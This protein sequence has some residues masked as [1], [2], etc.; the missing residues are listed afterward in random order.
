MELRCI[1]DKED[2][3]RPSWMDESNLS[4]TSTSHFRELDLTVNG[5]KEDTGVPTWFIDRGYARSIRKLILDLW[6]ESPAAA[7]LTWA[8]VQQAAATLQQMV[9]YSSRVLRGL[10]GPANDIIAPIVTPSLTSLHIGGASI[11]FGDT[12]ESFR[13]AML[14]IECVGPNAPLLRQL[15]VE[16]TFPISDAVQ[17]DDRPWNQLDSAIASSHQSL[18]VEVV[19]QRKV[20]ILR[21]YSDSD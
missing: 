9:T 12:T 18:K 7:R 14:M 16:D 13:W 2:A 10:A 17:I 3:V 6:T 21:N 5:F 8:F 19:M 1:V 11:G 15:V 4:F 20:Y